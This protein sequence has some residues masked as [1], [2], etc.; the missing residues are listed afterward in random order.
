MIH[1]YYGNGKGKT[2]AACGLAVRAAGSGMKVLFTQFFKNGKSSEISVLSSLNNIKCLFPASCFGRYKNMTDEQKEETKKIYGSLLSEITEK[3][4]DFGMIVLD[5][6]ISAYNYGIIPHDV[7]KEFLSREKN[8]C[9]IVLTGRNPS[10][11]LLDLA[12]YATEMRKEKHP[13][14]KGIKA[15]KGIEF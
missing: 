13:F 7:L 12:D 1:L 9:E 15:R 10:E 8:R 14:D 3:A 6:A 4:A 2:T 5:E 11:E